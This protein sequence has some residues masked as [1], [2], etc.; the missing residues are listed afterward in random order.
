MSDHL[1][2]VFNFNLTN[3]PPHAIVTRIMNSKG[4]RFYFYF[5]FWYSPQPQQAE[6]VFG[7]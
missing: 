3:P 6:G 1:H 5:Y 7:A 2:D 4:N